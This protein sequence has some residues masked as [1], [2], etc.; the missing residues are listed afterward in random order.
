MPNHRSPMENQ[1]SMVYDV[2]RGS[3]C[4]PMFLV[5]PSLF[6]SLPHEEAH[7]LSLHLIVDRCNMLTM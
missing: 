7:I 5:C 4:T 2:L 6:S 3:E 1:P